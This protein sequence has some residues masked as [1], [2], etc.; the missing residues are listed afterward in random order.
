M[1]KRM[2]MKE[3]MVLSSGFVQWSGNPKRTS[4]GYQL[5]LWVFI[6]IYQ[7]M[8]KYLIV[9]RKWWHHI[10]GPDQHDCDCDCNMWHNMWPW[11]WPWWWSHVT[12]PKAKAYKIVFWQN[13]Q[14]MCY[15][16]NI[17]HIWKS[18]LPMLDIKILSLIQICI[19][20][21]LFVPPP[22][23]AITNTTTK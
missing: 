14:T 10:I 19:C 11:P 2:V 1:I 17:S 15:W 12:W 20:L 6:Q 8:G 9:Y 16:I 3:D 5:W 4:W 23:K 7:Y 21:Y 22:N 18:S 13:L